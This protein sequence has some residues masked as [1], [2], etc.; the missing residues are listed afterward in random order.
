APSWGSWQLDE[1]ALERLPLPDDVLDLVLTRVGELGPD[2]RRVLQ[3]AAVLGPAFD[4]GILRRVLPTLPVDVCLRQA[5]RSEL[6]S[7]SEHGYGFVHDRVR[8]AMHKDLDEGAQ[9]N[10]HDRIAEVLEQRREPDLFALARHHAKGHWE[11]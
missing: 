4:A 9:T 11:L 5:L 6:L 1:R 3:C 10:L 8:E 7:V 2:A